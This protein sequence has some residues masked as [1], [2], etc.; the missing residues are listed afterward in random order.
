VNLEEFTAWFTGRSVTG[1]SATVPSKA[2]ASWAD[3]A[4]VRAYTDA[5]LDA[6]E[7]DRFHGPA[8]R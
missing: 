8:H 2:A 5:A 4:D 3:D 7:R 1:R 6:L